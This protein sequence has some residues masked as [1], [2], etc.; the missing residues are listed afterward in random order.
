MSHTVISQ[1]NETATDV[2][3]QPHTSEHLD[4]NVCVFFD[5]SIYIITGAM[6]V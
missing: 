5:V 6:I 2:G 3:T 1:V 4:A